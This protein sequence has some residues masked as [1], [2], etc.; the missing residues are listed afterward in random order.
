MKVE[1]RPFL[2]PFDAATVA[3]SKA[4][5]LSAQVPPVIVDQR[6]ELERVVVPT[7]LFEAGLMLLSYQPFTLKRGPSFLVVTVFNTGAE[8]IDARGIY[9]AY[10]PRVPRGR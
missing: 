4:L 3:P 8:P 10:G 2:L 9:C 7:V 1:A 5:A 6:R